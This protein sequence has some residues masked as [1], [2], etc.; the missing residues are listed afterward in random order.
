MD[1][2]QRD[3]IRKNLTRLLRYTI[4]SNILLATLE[5]RRV[6]GPEDLDDIV[7]HICIKHLVLSLEITYEFSNV[8]EI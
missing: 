1:T 6:L 2:W 4:C 8:S 3:H 7:S 5:E